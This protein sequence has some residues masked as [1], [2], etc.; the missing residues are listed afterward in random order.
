MMRSS[1]LFILFMLIGGL[2]FLL[3]S[4]PPF[5]SPQ[6]KS[7]RFSEL[8]DSEFLKNSYWYQGLAEIN[9]YQASVVKYG[10]LRPAEEVVHI[11]VT[12]KHDPI[13]LV[14]ADD[15][16]RPGLVDVLKFN[17]LTTIPTGI[18]TYREMISAFFANPEMNL[19]KLTFSSQEWC[20]QSFKELL[21]VGKRK[22]LWF[23]TYWDG[24]GRGKYEANFP[25]YLVLYDVLPVQLRALKFSENLKGHFE[26][27]PTQI[28][29]KVSQPI[30]EK[31]E[32][33]ITALQPLRV[34][35]GEFTAYRVQ[36]RH[37]GGEDRLWF[38]KDFPHRMLKWETY[39]GNSYLLKKSQRLAYW[40]LN[41]PGDEKYLPQ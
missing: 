26:M 7:N 25:E 15:W 24:Q 41:K 32:F 1:R 5:L 23:N 34:P 14:K 39:A 6:H 9:H 20:G 18:Y 13:L 27:L 21:N 8:L 30:W 12:E 4:A 11:L 37:S 3:S 36:I 40:E 2:L 29:S 31:A 28:S 33:E 38:E 35:A 16:K 22:G 10:I 17:Y 19:I